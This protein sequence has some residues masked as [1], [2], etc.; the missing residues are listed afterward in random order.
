MTEDWVGVVLFAGLYGWSMETDETQGYK[1]GLSS[2]SSSLSE[3]I[4]RMGGEAGDSMV[5][6][7]ADRGGAARAR[8][9]SALPPHILV[10]AASRSESS[11]SLAASSS[12]MMSTTDGAETEGEAP[13][14]EAVAKATMIAAGVDVAGSDLVKE[15]GCV[16]SGTREALT[17]ALVDPS[18]SGDEALLEDFLLTYRYFTTPHELVS[19]LASMFGAGAGEGGAGAP[20]QLR[21][22]ALMRALLETDAHL[23]A[24]TDGESMATLDN[25]L[26]FVDRAL[27]M[28]PAGEVVEALRELARCAIHVEGSLPDKA[29]SPLL[30]HLPPN[31]PLQMV[32]D[33]LAPANPK[34]FPAAEAASIVAS[35]DVAD[36]ARQVTLISFGL[37]SRIEPLEC[38]RSTFSDDPAAAPAFTAWTRFTNRMRA[39]LVSLVLAPQK[40]K[41]RIRLYTKLLALPHEFLKLSNFH[42]AL[43]AWI[44]LDVT[45]AIARLKVL[46]SAVPEAALAALKPIQILFEPRKNNANYQAA[47]FKATPPL[48]PVLSIF[49]SLLYKTDDA[50]PD[51]LSSGHVNFRKLRLM[52]SIMHKV[53]QY[54]TTPYYMQANSQLIKYLQSAQVYPESQWNEL[55]VKIERAKGRGKGWFS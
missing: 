41:D 35:L 21:V 8:V 47:L 33:R 49:S 46:R 26:T 16:V 23:F 36:V 3:V 34:A 48:V 50:Q 19:L 14:G 4:A 20:A 30:E 42:D 11:M 44:A 54:Q 27:R 24:G 39:W 28:R 2:S 12:S 25:L 17:W 13:V 32:L 53:L 45:P 22:L 38:L 52:G 31:A 55:S 37:F 10:Q 29:H 18:C 40:K 51:V 5:G 43:N 7:R 1:A 9:A 15:D 6:A